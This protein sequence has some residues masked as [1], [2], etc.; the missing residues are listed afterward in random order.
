MV[1]EYKFRPS[2]IFQ[3][4]IKYFWKPIACLILV[5]VLSLIPGNKLPHP[6]YIIPHFDK[7][8]HAGMYFTLC[9][10]A[11]A[12]FAKVRVGKGYWAAFITSIAFGG[13]FEILQET[14]TVNRSGNL[15]DFIANTCGALLALFAYRFVISGTKLERIF[16]VQ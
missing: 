7:L 15:Y 4:K 13:I 8:V 9:I 6:K 2:T 11:I 5:A 1:C 16:T 14:I 12:P 10:F 3:M